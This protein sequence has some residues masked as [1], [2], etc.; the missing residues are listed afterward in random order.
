MRRR[1]EISLSTKPRPRPDELPAHAGS[2]SRIKTFLY[3]LAVLVS[4]CITLAIGVTVGTAV[5]VTI[6]V[7]VVAALL[8]L[9]VRGVLDRLRIR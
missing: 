2:K 1:F 3:G 9:V 8:A 4:L 7:L 6:G 5:A